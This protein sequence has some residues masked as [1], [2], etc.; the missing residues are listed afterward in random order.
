MGALKSLQY[1]SDLSERRGTTEFTGNQHFRGSNHDCRIAVIV[2]NRP[3]MQKSMRSLPSGLRLRMQRSLVKS[4]K[5]R[6]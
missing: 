6:M 4:R 2:G 5:L 1:C 3:R